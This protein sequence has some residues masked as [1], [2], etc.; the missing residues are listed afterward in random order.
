M[1]IGDR[2]DLLRATGISA[3]LFA[4]SLI[5]NAIA[6]R[7]LGVDLSKTTPDR[8]PLTMWLV[9]MLSAPFIGLSGAFWYF[10]GST[11]PASFTTGLALGALMTGIGILLDAVFILPLRSGAAILLGYFKKW[12]YWLTLAI[13]TA[14]VATFGALR[15]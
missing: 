11:Q 14:A 4:V 9:G 10:S 13:L 3:A 12:Q 15:A 8:L 1:Q 5:I 6:G 2:V 7:I